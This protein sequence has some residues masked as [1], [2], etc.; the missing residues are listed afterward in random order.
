ME[1]KRADAGK[2]DAHCAFPLVL[3]EGTEKAVDRGPRRAVLHVKEVKRAVEQ[4]HIL[5][6]RNHVDGICFKR[7][8]VG[9]GHHVQRIDL[10][11]YRLK[12]TRDVRV[13]VGH[14]DKRHSGGLRNVAKQLLCRLQAA[15][16]VPDTDDQGKAPFAVGVVRLRAVLGTCHA[17]TP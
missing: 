17:C 13:Q 11:E 6:R 2:H 4:L 14:D 10:R 9:Y 5:A 16:G 3:R 12:T 8:A 1:A 15:G 7:H